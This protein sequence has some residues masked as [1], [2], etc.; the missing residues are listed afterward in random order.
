MVGHI[1]L[2]LKNDWSSRMITWDGFVVH[3][4][5]YTLSRPSLRTLPHHFLSPETVLLRHA[6]TKHWR[7]LVLCLKMTID[8]GHLGCRLDNFSDTCDQVASSFEPYGKLCWLSGVFWVTYCNQLIGF[9]IVDIMILFGQNRRLFLSR[10][11]WIILHC[12]QWRTGISLGFRR[13]D[14]VQDKHKIL[15]TILPQ[16]PPY[17][18]LFEW[19]PL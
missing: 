11:P 8:P 14:H 4:Y 10:L 7:H 1:K 5:M 9:I 13:F 16:I 17:F 12:T 3:M 2:A 6:W 18:R 15:N 19:N